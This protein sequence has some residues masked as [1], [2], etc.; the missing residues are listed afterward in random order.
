MIKLIWNKYHK[1]PFAFKMLG[2]FAL[3]I[4]VGI[5]FG[6]RADVLQPF[7]TI[8]LRLLKLVALPIIFLTIISAVNIMD[9]HELGKKGW[10]LLLYYTVTTAAAMGIGLSLAYLF[11]PGKHLTLTGVAQ[12][13]PKSLKWSDFLIH[14]VPQNI[15]GTFESGNLLGIM[16]LGMLVGLGIAV[17]RASNNKE[18][19]AQGE[20]L[21]HGFEALNTLSFKVLDWLLAYVPFGVFAIA[22]VNFGQGALQKM[23]SLVE[24]VG[25]FYLGLFIHWL[26]V[27]S[28][29][30]RLKGVPVFT[31]LKDTRDAYVMGFVTSSSLA[32]LPV[33]IDSAK[34]AGVSSE[35]ADFTLPLGAIF[36]SD[37]GALRMGVS[38]VFAANIAH[39]ALAPLHMVTIVLVG[40]LLSVGTAGVPAAGLVSLSA[41]LVLFGLPLEVVGVIAGIDAILGMGGTA[42]NVMGDIV[43]AAYVDEGV[44]SQTE[45]DKQTGDDDA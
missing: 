16:I 25:I 5:I 27:Y 2:G 33:A 41:I 4:L 29:F 26:V 10:R 30:L 13:A 22:A 32:S 21:H 8:L 40:T 20:F 24:F 9:L 15:V 35:T 18:H 43:G 23:G 19:K 28:S 39:V 44:H 37:G 38:I 14:M 1:T 31:F 12:Q 11:E 36:N 42:S 45:H 34:K 3:G 7:A 17:L 6:Q